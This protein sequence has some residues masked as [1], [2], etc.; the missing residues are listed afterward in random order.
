MKTTIRTGVKDDLPSVLTLIKE[1]AAYEKAEHEVTMTLDQLEKDG[2]GAEP[3][4]HF[5][6]AENENGIV[7]MSFYYYRYSTWK[8]KRLYLEDIIVTD[9]E[10]G[11]GIG[12]DLFKITIEKALQSGCTGM[13]WQVLDWNEPAINFY[14]KHIK[15][16]L[17]DEWINCHL[18]GEEE[19]KEAQER[20]K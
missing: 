7:G 12:R 1:L 2:F 6:V 14:K 3:L 11:K 13:M 16:H 9:K 20:L 19:M 10:R 5:I 17:D 18:M 15:A 4:Y 8:G